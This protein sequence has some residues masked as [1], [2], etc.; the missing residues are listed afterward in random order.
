MLR[1]S[2]QAQRSRQQFSGD[3]TSAPLRLSRPTFRVS[4]DLAL[5]R[6]GSVIGAKVFL[7]VICGPNAVHLTAPSSDTSS[8]FLAS[9]EN[10]IGSSRNTGLQKPSTTIATAYSGAMQ[11]KGQ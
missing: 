9:T 6:Q 3:P 10:Y 11:G 4:P 7:C 8:N 2:A 1:R 5:F